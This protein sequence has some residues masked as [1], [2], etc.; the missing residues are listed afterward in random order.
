M[1]LQRLRAF[2]A[3]SFLAKAKER[4]A[5]ERSA[6][7]WAA[8]AEEVCLRSQSQLGARLDLGVAAH[9]LT[10]ATSAHG[11]PALRRAMS[12]SLWTRPDGSATTPALV[13]LGAPLNEGWLSRLLDLAHPESFKTAL[14]TET[15]APYVASALKAAGLFPR[16]ASPLLW[17]CS[18]MGEVTP[19][20]WS[21]RFEASKR[22]L[23]PSSPEEAA[24]CLHLARMGPEKIFQLSKKQDSSMGLMKGSSAWVPPTPPAPSSS[25][26]RDD[27]CAWI[28][29]WLVAASTKT[30]QA[31]LGPLDSSSSNLAGAGP[32]RL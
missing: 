32:R 31:T 2:L 4:L 15:L 29:A 14:S 24:A 5:A 9:A 11:E 22:F 28:E 16:R 26:A 23:E 27:L 25:G 20:E 21:E 17:L 13:A 30:P 12:R 10:S 3:P 8:C 1:I 18:R 6:A 19:D 7:L